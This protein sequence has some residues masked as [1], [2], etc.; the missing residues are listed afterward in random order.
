MVATVELALKNNV[1]S[2]II[3]LACEISHLLTNMVAMV[4]LTLKNNGRPY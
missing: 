4:E 2:Y 3:C 1:R